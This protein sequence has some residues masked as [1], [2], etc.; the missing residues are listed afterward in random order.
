MR[1]FARLAESD[2]DVALVLAQL[3]SSRTRTGLATAAAAA[4]RCRRRAPPI[5]RQRSRGSDARPGVCRRAAEALIDVFGST[6]GGLER[7]L[8]DGPS[9]H[10]RYQLLLREMSRLQ[11]FEEA[12]PAE[13][14]AILDRVSLHFLTQDGTARRGGRDPAVQRRAIAATPDIARRHREAVF[15]LAPQVE[16]VVRQFSRDFNVVLARGIRRMFAVALEQYR[17]TLA[18]AR[19]A[20]FLRRPRAGAAAAA[21]DG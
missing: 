4:H 18:G 16:R 19:G 2:E 14:R 10:P 20:G 6:P 9:A 3:G 12:A 7:L 15:A 11:R 5:P 13:I 8:L 17:R 1:M 21:P